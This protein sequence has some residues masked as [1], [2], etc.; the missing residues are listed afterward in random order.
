MPAEYKKK[1]SVLGIIA[2]VIAILALLTS[3]MPIINNGSFVLAII[4]LIMAVIAAV[5]AQKGKT[6]G[7][8]ITITGII[9]SVLAIVIVL[10][11]QSMYGKAIDDAT[12]SIENGS[13]PVTESSSDS[14]SSSSSSSTE[15][16]YSHLAVGQSVSLDND[17]TVT[18]NAIDTALEN[19]DGSSVVGITVTYVNNG[20]DGA[21]YN[22]YDWKGESASGAQESPIYYSDAEG[23]LSSGT[24]AAGG[25]VTGTIYFKGDTQ[26]VL[27]FSSSLAKNASAGWNVA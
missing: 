1:T 5:R 20:E 2:L 26:R 14:S 4:S 21:S 9:L 16:D 19:Y 25:T 10:V 7:K 22:R 6:G 24:L 17:L 15:T 3:F 8:G 11:T 23:E 18:V 27:Y 12:Q 13:Q